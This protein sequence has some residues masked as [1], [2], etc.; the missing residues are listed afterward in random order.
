MNFPEV[1][2]ALNELDGCQQDMEALPFFISNILPAITFLEIVECPAI[3]VATFARLADSLVH[4]N[5]LRLGGESLNMT[6]ELALETRCGLFPR[7][8]SLSISSYSPS[9]VLFF[10]SIEPA[11]PIEQLELNASMKTP[12]ARL[13]THL[14]RTLHHLR[15]DHDTLPL[16]ATQD[17]Y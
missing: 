1:R 9:F 3:S 15:M 10:A 16:A 4:L 2:R 8:K 5:T 6:P 12:S 7:L 17:G 11:P 13:V 14:L